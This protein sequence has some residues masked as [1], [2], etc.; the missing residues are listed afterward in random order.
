[1]FT[2][3]GPSMLAW[4]PNQEF[5]MTR[6][7]RIAA[8]CALAVGALAAP[9]V[10]SAT[11]VK[12]PLFAL[13]LKG[14]QVSTWEQQHDPQFACDATVRGNGSQQLGYDLRKPITLKLVVPKQGKA[15][16]ALPKDT[17]AEHGFPGFGVPFR[18]DADREGSV[19]TIQAPGGAC[20]G[21]GGYTGGAPKRDCDESRQGRV[22]LQLGYAAYGI[23][24]AP[25]AGRFQ[26]AG[27]YRSFIDTPVPQVDP[28]EPTEGKAL[29]LTFEN[30]PYWAMGSASPSSDELVPTTGKLPLKQLRTLAKGKTVKTS[31]AKRVRY[32]E[33]DFKGD[34]LH[35]WNIKLKR[36]K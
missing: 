29:S 36:I 2:G 3:A 8:A 9:A 35:T 34:T 6:I 16:L 33:G 17:L 11:P 12:A 1:M 28:T 19:Q 31:G 4:H 15:T 25:P 27:R 23:D 5:H 7:A 10:A 13:T 20:N 21:T 22:E 26:V 18:V 14:T 24:P 30:C 32:A